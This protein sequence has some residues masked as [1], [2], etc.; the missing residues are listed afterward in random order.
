MEPYGLIDFKILPQMVNL[1]L[2]EI[3]S[4]E[5]I[6]DKGNRSDLMFCN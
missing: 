3:N 2:I 1:I 4:I 5:F 6:E